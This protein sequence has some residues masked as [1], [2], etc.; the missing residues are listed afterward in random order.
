MI[1][2][3]VAY[4]GG[5]HVPRLILSIR[6]S[7]SAQAHEILAVMKDLYAMGALCFDL[8][9][10]RHIEALRELKGIADDEAL[11]GFPHLDAEEGACYLG[12][13]LHRVQ[14]RIVATIG[15]NVC[16]AHL[17]RVLL[18]PVSGAGVLTQKE[19]DR[20]SF[21]QSRLDKALFLF[22][23]RESP[24]VFLGERY[25]DW[26][27]GLGR[28][29][30]LGRMVTRIRERGFIPLYSGW[31]TTYS[32]PKVPAARLS[33]T[34]GMPSS[35]LPRPAPSSRSSTGPF[36]ASIR[37]PTESSGKRPRRPS[38]SSFLTSRSPAP[39]PR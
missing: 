8:P 31:W 3:P 18:P 27:L 15:K 39:W 1:K 14:D 35:T 16:P 38:P 6:P 28:Q 7:P 20:I 24:F 34:G 33:S 19:I 17:A 2:I 11:I 36:S 32:L 10:P 12:L 21:D 37:W 29:D 5:K 25:G 9:T 26:L 4:L 22:N 13:P 23:P 30:V